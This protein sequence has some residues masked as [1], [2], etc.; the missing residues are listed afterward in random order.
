MK[1]V[2]GVIGALLLLTTAAGQQIA[3]EEW[4]LLFGQ[5]VEVKSLTRTADTV[6]VWQRPT[7]IPSGFESMTS[8]VLYHCKERYMHIK[9]MLVKPNGQAER[10]LSNDDPPIYPAPATTPM[11]VMDALCA[12]GEIGKLYRRNLK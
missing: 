8:L 3:L 5:E 9:T 12:T 11:M 10:R 1:T 4:H 7:P 6:L 2:I